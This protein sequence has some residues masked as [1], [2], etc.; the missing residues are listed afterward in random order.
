M[1]YGVV[2][3]FAETRANTTVAH[4]ARHGRGGRPEIGVVKAG[5]SHPEIKTQVIK[6]VKVVLDTDQY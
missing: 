3:R 1:I 2:L 6:K 4:L 5:F